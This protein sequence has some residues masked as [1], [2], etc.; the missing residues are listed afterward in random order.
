MTIFSHNYVPTD[1]FKIK[2]LPDAT[3]EAVAA[4]LS[5]AIDFTQLT[6]KKVSNL[7]QLSFFKSQNNAVTVHLTT[8][9]TMIFS[10]EQSLAQLPNFMI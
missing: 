10:A 2:C 9:L 4:A 5:T 3:Q 1:C 8:T 6:S 7:S